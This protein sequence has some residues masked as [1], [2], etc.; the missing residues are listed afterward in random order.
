MSLYF[1]TKKSKQRLDRN[2]L[3]ENFSRNLTSQ[4]RTSMLLDQNTVQP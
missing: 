3:R 4:D 1:A 2:Q